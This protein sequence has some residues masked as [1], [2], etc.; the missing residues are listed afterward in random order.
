MRVLVITPH[1]WPEQFRIND[2]VT[3]LVKS[4]DKVDVL[5]GLPNYPKGVLHGGYEKN[6]LEFQNYNGA[7][8]IHVNHALRGKRVINRILNYVT[9]PLALSWKAYKLSKYSNYDVVFT[10]QLSPIFCALPSLVYKKMTNTKSVLLV[11]DLWPECLPDKTP[12]AV[13]WLIDKFSKYLYENM[14]V[15]LGQSESFVRVISDKTNDSCTIEYFPSWSDL[16]VDNDHSIELPDNFTSYEGGKI[17]YTGNVGQPQDID[18][19]IALA[20][21]IKELSLGYKIFIVGSGVELNRLE[22]LIVDSGVVEQIECLG[23]Y[24]LSYMNEFIAQADLLLITLR[25]QKGYNMT[26]PAKLQTYLAGGKCIIGMANGEVFEFI[27]SHQ[28]GVCFNSGEA[29]EM[30]QWLSNLETNDYG[31]VDECSYRA[32]RLSVLEFNRVE[33]M[34]KLRRYLS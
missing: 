8:V 6:P 9:L 22:M 17:L 32:E 14:D 24:P 10:F 5:T 19:I 34:K 13:I 27:N 31:L 28:V 2:I 3:Q 20:R 25:D 15:V 18:S 26:I 21:L 16:K 12:K 23:R 33:L 4:G 30:A 29:F 11:L 1:F 7:S